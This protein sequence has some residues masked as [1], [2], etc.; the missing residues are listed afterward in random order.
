MA[1][2]KAQIVVLA[3]H[4]KPMLVNMESIMYNT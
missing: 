4:H 3:V 1:K 2:M